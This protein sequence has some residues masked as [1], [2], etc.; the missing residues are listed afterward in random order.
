MN[1]DE[2]RKD[3]RKRFCNACDAGTCYTRCDKIYNHLESLVLSQAEIITK[4]NTELHEAL[5][6]IIEL[7]E[8]IEGMKAERECPKSL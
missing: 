7:K 8:T 5:I 2:L 6:K 3:I 4:T 1:A